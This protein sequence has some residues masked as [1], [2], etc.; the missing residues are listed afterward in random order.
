MVAAANFG[1][2]WK[3]LIISASESRS[4][5]RA[6][7]GGL[8]GLSCGN[9]VVVPSASTPPVPV[10]CRKKLDLMCHKSTPFLSESRCEASAVGIAP[11]H[12]S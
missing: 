3:M 5:N 10:V 9:N 8:F 7:K 4:V 2:K 1:A 12:G 6:R 11:A